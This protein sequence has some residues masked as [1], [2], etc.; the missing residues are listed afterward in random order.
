MRWQAVAAAAVV[1]MPAIAVAQQD[2]ARRPTGAVR[3]DTAQGALD[4]PARGRAGRARNL[5]LTTE[6]V[7]ELQQAL[8]SNGCDP[9]PVDG[10]VGP[11]TRQAMTCARRQ[12]NVTGTGNR[13]LFSALNL[14]FA[15][16]G[17]A[18][19]QAGQ[20]REGMMRDTAAT[21][22]TRTGVRSDTAAGARDT[23]G[24]RRDTAGAA[25]VR[26]DTTGRDTTRGRPPTATDTTRRPPR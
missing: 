23:S 14:S 3:Q 9:G 15:A 5:G 18:G 20:R 19:A 21:Q 11:R 8:Q 22:R 6:Q 16:Q 1:L 2:T 12:L 17:A 26:R 13:E 7:Q 4:R 24:M 25:G 10:I